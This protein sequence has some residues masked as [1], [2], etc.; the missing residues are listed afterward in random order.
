MEKKRSS[1]SPNDACEKMFRAVTNFPGVRPRH[2]ISHRPQE[3]RLLSPASR[4][5]PAT[6]GNPSVKTTGIQTNPVV[7]PQPKSEKLKTPN[8]KGATESVAINFDYTTPPSEMTDPAKTARKQGHVQAAKVAPNMKQTPPPSVHKP[9][10]TES[11]V[12]GNHKPKAQI[13]SQVNKEEGKKTGIH[14]EDRF[15]DYINRAKVKIRTMSNAGEAAKVDRS[16][17]EY[18]NRAKLKIRA[19]SSIGGGKYDHYK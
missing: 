19:M 11:P 3:P 15:T 12:E 9:L 14:I 18:I 7:P 5:S 2:R 6:M 4:A 16:F 8:K 13:S 17:S 1:S 10:K